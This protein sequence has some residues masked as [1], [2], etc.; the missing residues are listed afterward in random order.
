MTIQ[1]N[2]KRVYKRKHLIKEIC[3][4]FVNNKIS[5]G[6]L[7][8]RIKQQKVFFEKPRK[9]KNDKNMQKMWA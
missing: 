1:I 4:D 8:E 2:I 3:E 6:L 7:L 5:V 9:R